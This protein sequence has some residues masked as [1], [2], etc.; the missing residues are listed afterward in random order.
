[1]NS[2]M[3][4]SV[5]QMRN[6][7]RVFS[8]L[9]RD[10]LYVRAL[11]ILLQFF[12]FSVFLILCAVF[13]NVNNYFVGLGS[14]VTFYAFLKN[15]TSK[16]EVTKIKT[17]IQ[18]WPEVNTVKVI[19]PD[20]GL[21]ILKKSLGKESDILSTLDVNPLPTTF[22]INIKSEFTEKI[23]IQQISDKLK[24]IS[25]VEW[26]DTTEK[27]LGNIVS[28]RKVI[29]NVFL[30]GIC[31][32]ITIIVLSLRIMANCLINRYRA[33]FKLLKFLGASNKFI[34]L[35]FIFEGFLESFLTAFVSILTTNYILL[36]IKENFEK[37]EIHVQLL[38]LNFYILF[39]ILV[40]VVGAL[41]NIPSR[42]AI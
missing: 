9:Y 22:E 16:E 7:L 33:N 42:K 5:N 35:P 31:L 27:Y 4:S 11:N 38:P 26:L 15:S 39:I 3:G 29:V 10:R 37:L 40:S 1:M 13:F 17:I 20:E 19:K 34:I 24:K 18:N 6:S 36:L 41:S 14:R 32:F 2:E 23:Y 21:R 25:A 12:L 28:I 8:L 30:A